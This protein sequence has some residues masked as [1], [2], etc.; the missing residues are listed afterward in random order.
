M[1]SF[2]PV[3]VMCLLMASF[4]I[5][6]YGQSAGISCPSCMHVSYKISNTPSMFRIIMERLRSGM[7][8]ADQACA[9]NM[10]K[11]DV[12]PK[13][14]NTCQRILINAVA[15]G[16]KNVFPNATLES[17]VTVRGCATVGFLNQNPGS[18]VDLSTL[19]EKDKN[20]LIASV[21]KLY[22]QWREVTYQGQ[23]C[24]G[25]LTNKQLGFHVNLV[26]SQND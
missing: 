9:D 3:P 26:K 4:S 22:A 6:V 16:L 14:D 25:L 19:P 1:V 10:V 8:I 21:Q 12:C 5:H 15:K 23:I 24:N 20:S 2:N 7:T 18:C 13:P 11:P 17:T